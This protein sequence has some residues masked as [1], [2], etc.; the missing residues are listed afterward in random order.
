M[1]LRWVLAEGV[2]VLTLNLVMISGLSLTLERSLFSQYVRDRLAEG[3]IPMVQMR[4]ISDSIDKYVNGAT[5]AR[6]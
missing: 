6:T 2:S 4:R 5:H 1:A 3:M